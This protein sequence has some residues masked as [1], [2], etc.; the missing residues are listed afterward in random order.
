[1]EDYDDDVYEGSGPTLEAAFE[2]AWNHAK[3]NRAQP[4]TYPAK[5]IAIEAE[6]PIHA[7]IVTIGPPDG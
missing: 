5:L 2:D 6:N 1:M 7:Y 3:K 4:G